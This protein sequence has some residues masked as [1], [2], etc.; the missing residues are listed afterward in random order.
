MAKKSN[1]QG[2]LPLIL[3]SRRGR[4]SS[5]PAKCGECGQH[6]ERIWRYAESNRESPIF[7]CERCKPKVSDRSFGYVDVFNKGLFDRRG[8]Y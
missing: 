5:L 3:I 6:R 7:L 8:R 4:L 2:N 1:A